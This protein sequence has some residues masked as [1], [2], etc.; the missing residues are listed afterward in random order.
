MKAQVKIS[1]YQ[2]NLGLA[3][4]N[5][6]PYILLRS[7]NLNG[8]LTYLAVNPQN[9]DTRTIKATE[10]SNT[11]LCSFEQLC[12]KMEDTPYIKALLR[13]RSKALPIQDAGITHA[14]PSEKG[15]TLTIDLCPSHKGLDKDIFTSLTGAF[16]NIERPIP[17]ALSLTGKFLLTH[18]DDIQW[19]KGLVSSGQI[20][21]TWINHTYHHHYNP[22]TLISHNFLLEPGT[23]LQ[24]ELLL[25]ESAMLEQGLIPSVFF[26]FPG[27][28]SSQQLVNK[29]TSYGLI[30]I[31]SDAWLAKGQQAQPG[32]LVLIHGNG[33]EPIGVQDFIKLLASE[34]AAVHQKQ[35][36]LYDLRTSA[37]RQ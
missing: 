37:A 30:T 10:L 17:V 15:I 5:N 28:V 11:T 14:F 36:L 34:T 3:D 19:L 35:W 25:L 16:K 1:D 8:I 9:L 26:R 12:L 13:A 24:S 4:Y 2:Y 22:A 20:T 21:I 7:F 29:V 18:E 27:L 32:S 23:D 6:Q 33:N 31:G